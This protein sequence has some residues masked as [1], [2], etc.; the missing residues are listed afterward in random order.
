MWVRICTNGNTQTLLVGVSVVTSNLANCKVASVKKLW[1]C[2][3]YDTSI[4]PLSMCICFCKC[5]VVHSSAICNSFKLE[6]VQVP[7][8][9]RVGQINRGTFEQWN[10]KQQWDWTTHNNIDESRKYNVEWK[11][12]RH[13]RIYTCILYES[14]SVKCKNETVL[15]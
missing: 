9:Y 2:K 14:V 15:L 3:F 6:I 10:T 5:S 4:P 1:L 13:K 8:N 7:I 11:K 12:I